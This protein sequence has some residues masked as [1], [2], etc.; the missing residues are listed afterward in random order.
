M[1]IMVLFSGCTRTVYVPQT[2]T[3]YRDRAQYDSIYTRDSVFVKL[4]GDTVYLYRDRWRDRYHTLR[5]TVHLVDSV[6]YPVEVVKIKEVRHVPTIYRVSLWF[7]AAV[8]L[9]GAWML[10]KKLL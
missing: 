3:E 2:H 1:I 6:A 10:K 9:V 8:T 5:D 7:A 4:A